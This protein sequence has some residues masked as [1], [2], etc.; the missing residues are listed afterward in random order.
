MTCLKNDP[1]VQYGD[2]G[3]APNLVGG[4]GIGECGFNV[5][6]AQTLG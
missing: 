1:A 4:L 2:S 6:A 5:Q 3:A